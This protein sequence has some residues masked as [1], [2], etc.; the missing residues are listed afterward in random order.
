MIPHLNEGTLYGSY[1]SHF[2]CLDSCIAPCAGESGPPGI[3]LKILLGQGTRNPHYDSAWRTKP[4]LLLPLP[5]FPSP[6]D[7][8]ACHWVTA[9][10]TPD[11]A[12]R[13]GWAGANCGWHGESSPRPEGGHVPTHQKPVYCFSEKRRKSCFAVGVLPVKYEKNGKKLN[14]SNAIHTGGNTFPLNP[15]QPD[16]SPPSLLRP[17]PPTQDRHA[18]LLHPLGASAAATAP[19]VGPAR[20]R[21]VNL[22][23]TAHHDEVFALHGHL[24]A[25]DPTGLA[26]RPLHIRFTADADDA[27]RCLGVSHR[28]FGKF[29][30]IL[31]VFPISVGN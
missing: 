20:R 10:P 3:F 21:P 6:P 22:A 24:P 15:Q 8:A 28:Q 7:T 14:S 4:A 1:L 9:T 23:G 27:R 26:F 11:L 25:P 19:P 13:T 31:R 17:A 18:V 5:S 12:G 2:P 30:A 16:H 29:L